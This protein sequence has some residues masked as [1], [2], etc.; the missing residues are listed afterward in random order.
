MIR[1]A[2]LQ[3]FTLLV[4]ASVQTFNPLQP[5]TWM[6]SNLSVILIP[7]SWLYDIIAVVTV[8]SIGILYGQQ[9]RLYPWIPKNNLEAFL[10]LFEPQVFASGIAHFFAGGILM[11]SYLGLLGGKFNSLVTPS[12]QLN[13]PHVFM[14]FS[15]AFSSLAIWKD[16]HFGNANLVSFPIIQQTGN[17]Q[18]ARQLSTLVKTSLLH[19]ALNLR[20]F[21]IF[22]AAFGN[23]SCHKF[24]QSYLL[25]NVIF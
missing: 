23:N 7:S 2:L 24:S 6:S 5:L 3:F 25:I 1:S 21:Y 20:W 17:A 12:G 13:V 4:F 18:L 14:I 15:G 11:R 16:F 8:I 10:K 19:V 9:L 22:Y